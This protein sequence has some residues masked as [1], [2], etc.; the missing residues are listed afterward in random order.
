MTVSWGAGSSP[1]GLGLTYVL[2]VRLNNGGWSVAA[3]TSGRSYSYTVPTNATYVQFRVKCRDTNG[4]ES[5]YRTGNNLSVIQWFT[6]TFTGSHSVFGNKTQGRIEMY[7][8]GTLTLAKGDYDVFVVG[9]GAAGLMGHMY[10]A[11]YDHIGAGGPSGRTDSG[12]VTV[13]STKTYN[14]NIGAGGSGLSGYASRNRQQRSTGGSSSAC[15]YSAQGGH[16]ESRKDNYYNPMVQ[17]NDGGSSGGRGQEWNSDEGSFSSSDRARSGGSDGDAQGTTTRAFGESNG[18][19]YAGG[20]GGGSKSVGGRAD[21]YEQYIGHGGAGGGGDGSYTYKPSY[22]QPNQVHR[23][24]SGTPNTG[25]G[26]GG[27]YN[28][29]TDTTGAGGSGIAIVRWGY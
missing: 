4:N 8:S 7:E 19:L 10:S 6:P 22:S 5:N 26:G 3:T 13:A 20:G 12:S 16:S 14:V 1:A 17:Q 25:G 24:V 15:G 28:S 9:G 23:A 18:T 2:E 29:N 11:T 27:S 21:G